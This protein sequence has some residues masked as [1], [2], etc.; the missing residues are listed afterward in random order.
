M[1]W[2]R[3]L[4]SLLFLTCRDAAPLISHAIDRE[5]PPLDRTAVRL[6]LSICPSCRRYR[7]QLT[8][9]RRVLALSCDRLTGPGVEPLSRQARSRIRLALQR[10][11]GTP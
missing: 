2:V 11:A 4:R 10:G 3:G 5:L 9:M 1:K 8:W 7:G 6:H